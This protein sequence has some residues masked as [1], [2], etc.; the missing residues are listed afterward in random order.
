MEKN[1]LEMYY[2]FII[3]HLMTELNKDAKASMQVGMPKSQ[4]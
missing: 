4:Q 2:V 3:I 1:L